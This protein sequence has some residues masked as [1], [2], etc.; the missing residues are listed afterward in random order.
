[1]SIARS[2]PGLAAL[3]VVALLAPGRALAQDEDPAEAFRQALRQYENG[4]YAGARASFEEANRI[5]P[6]VRVLANIADCYA[7]EGRTADSVRTYRRF[8]AESG[9]AVPG[10]A[11]RLVE[12]RLSEL[13][14]RVCD[15]R[16]IVEPAGATIRV[17]DAEVGTAPMAEPWAVDAGERVVEVRLAG[18]RT[19]R[20]TVQ[21]RAGAD[22]EVAVTLVPDGGAAE[23]PA[24]AEE[25]PLA[26][27]TEAP[28]RP[29]EPAPTPL[30]RGPLMWTGV[31]LTVALA[32]AGTVTGVVALGQ[33]REYEDPATSAAR[34]RALY[35]DHE[36]MPLVADVLLDAAV[37]TGVLTLGLILFAGPGDDEPPSAEQAM[38]T[39]RLGD[40]GVGCDLHLAF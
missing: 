40:G 39:P 8:L 34:R 11:R 16:V 2:L 21:A 31:V 38:L 22:L 32:A 14:P 20:R 23:V 4:D 6:D 7:H 26:R 5:A 9:D 18:H 36:T 3:L 13:R 10:P 37:V 27:E 25:Q 35:D 12:R 33:A 29:I 24:G 19:E 15:L 17:D 30:G 1:M 28:A